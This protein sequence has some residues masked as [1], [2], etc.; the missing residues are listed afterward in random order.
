MSKNLRLGLFAVVCFVQLVVASGAIAEHERTL[1]DGEVYRFRL[2]PVDPNDPFRGRYVALAYEASTMPGAVA[3]SSDRVFAMIA[4]NAE[5]DAYF[6]ELREDR[7]ETGDYI[8]T[9]AYSHFQGG[10]QVIIP[11]NR[12]YADEA[13]ALRMEKLYLQGE[14][15]RDAYAMV[16]VRNGHGVIESVTIRG[17]R[18]E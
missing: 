18:F 15:T 4:V 14:P 17:E 12:F 3:P 7:P 8:R 13:T 6:A 16:R 10:A 5:G 11:F 2:A 9:N 1:S